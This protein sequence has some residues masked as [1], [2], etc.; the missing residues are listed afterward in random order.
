MHLQCLLTCGPIY[1]QPGLY[2]LL[3]PVFA[4]TYLQ[5][6]GLGAAAEAQ[7]LLAEHKQCFLNA[8]S[9]PRS[10][11]VRERELH[12]LQSIAT[13]EQ[14]GGSNLVRGI[15]A[16]RTPARIAQPC[17][18]LLTRFLQNEN[19]LL[20]LGV[21]NQRVALEVVDLPLVGAAQPEEEAP[22]ASGIGER[23]DADT[24]NQTQL[25]LKMLQSSIEQRYGEAAAE[26]AEQEAMARAEDEKLPK[27]DRVKR[28][29][30]A[31]QAKTRRETLGAACMASQIPLPAV[32][33]EREAALLLEM[34]ER[35]KA[36]GP[37]MQPLSAQAL[38]DAAF[39]TFVNSGQSLNCVSLSSDAALVAGGFADSSV[40]VYDL[41][42]APQPGPSTMEIDGRQ[43]D[44]RP[45]HL[46]GHTAPVFATDFSP[47]EQLL[48]SCSGDGSIRLW[49]MELQVGLAAYRGHMLPVWDVAFAP[50][51]G[52]YFASAGADR[53]ARIWN[54]ERSQAL[55]VFVGHQADV[56]VVRWHPNCHYV[57]TG[58][59]DCTVRLW[60]LRSG[61]CAR[62]LTGHS[63]S[64]S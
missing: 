50:H 24:I 47:D 2:R 32:P 5:M 38:P 45:T 41:R 57:A 59:S 28:Q 19:L 54:T 8:A 3:Y 4:H 6:V 36:G 33:E 11:R 62:I 23:A 25:D 39:F 60:D 37:G 27:R 42:S 20:M 35:E 43:T 44:G 7:A 18:D 48:L 64:V 51:Y 1:L 52:F 17:Y 40:R 12:E 49:S 29:K 31:A 63:S 22:L 30:E 10:L 56:D 26:V 14:L 46:S 13:P 9:N 61:G 58:S 53:T 21:V 15:R 34:K 16:A 55:R